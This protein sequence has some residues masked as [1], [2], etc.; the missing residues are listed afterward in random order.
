MI[1][2]SPLADEDTEHELQ[3]QVESFLRG[4]K[5]ICSNTS[6]R[7]K[8][9][10]LL[11]LVKQIHLYGPLKHSSFFQN[12]GKAPTDEAMHMATLAE[13]RVQYSTQ[14]SENVGL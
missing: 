4:Y 7:P 2:F 3:V 1:A 11:H 9:H 6:F 12:G 13:P 10:F 5:K 14:T 8:H